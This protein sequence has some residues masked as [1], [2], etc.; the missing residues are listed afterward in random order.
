M[1]PS[2][3]LREK[4]KGAKRAKIIIV[5]KCP[6]NLSAQ[7]QFVIASKLEPE[8]DQAVFFS[9]ITYNEKVFGKE[10]EIAVEALKNYKILLVTGIA[11]CKPLV[12]FLESKNCDF[13]HLRF[14]DHH[15]F[16]KSDKEKIR[17]EFEAL[18]GEKKIIL[19]TEKDYVRTFSKENSNIYY[20]PIK[21]KFLE[22]ANDFDKMILNYVQKNTRNS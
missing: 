10:S 18:E 14:A 6:E 3:N 9:S 22:S 19:T 2:G 8:L 5:T 15:F 17:N 21:T 7:E 16:T 11:N 12:E 13:K 20:L 1:L 4:K